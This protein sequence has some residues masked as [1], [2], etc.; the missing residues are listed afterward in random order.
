MFLAVVAAGTVVMLG[1]LL[2]DLAPRIPLDVDDAHRVVSTLSRSH[3]QLVGVM[4]VCIAVAIPVTATQYTP[5]LLR[6]F[7]VDRV[8][9]AVISAYA[10][11]AAHA[12]WVVYLSRRGAISEG[13]VASVVASSS[14]AFVLVVPYFFY[15][16]RFVE[17]STLIQR[18]RDDGVKALRRAS[19]QVSRRPSAKLELSHAVHDLGSLVLKAV[20]GMGRQ[21]AARAILAIREL[22]ATYGQRKDELDEAWFVATKAEFRGLSQGAR[23]LVTAE[24]CWLEVAALQDLNR[25]FDAALA[26]MPDAIV[27]IADA[28]RG[29]GEDADDRDDAPV[30]QNVVR[31]LNSMLRSA[32]NDE[33]PRAIY[34]VLSQY[35]ILAER[36]LSRRPDLAKNIAKYYAYYGVRAR[37][38]KM[39]FIP[40]MFVYDLGALV[41]VASKQDGAATDGILDEL[42]GLAGKL[43]AEP[44][45]ALG[46]ALLVTLG[47]TRGDLSEA[48]QAR[49]MERVLHLPER[50]VQEAV[51]VLEHTA[52]PRYHELSAR[53]LDVN[54]LPPEVVEALQARLSEHQMDFDT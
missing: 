24:R 30:L 8:H 50:V 4:F 46:S 12:N 41:G 17:P 37:R 14:I 18:I 36:C 38:K 31:A 54:Y 47:A 40:E 28:V 19:R 9:V 10:L 21:S 13:L 26:H 16:I 29:I 27:L 42:L 35:D 23:G 34:D 5:K 33:N 32:I 49:I 39:D 15:V 22:L 53:P 25:A 3:T 2:L 44:T 20:S 11:A 7:L 45:V 48:Q 1:E 43:A 51:D 6:L 52:S